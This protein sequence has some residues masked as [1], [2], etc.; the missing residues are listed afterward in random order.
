MTSSDILEN[1]KRN[2]KYR[3]MT[4]EQEMILRYFEKSEDIDDFKTSTEIMSELNMMSLGF[5]FKSPERIGKALSFA[6][7]T[8]IKHSKRQVYGYIIKKKQSDI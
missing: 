3:E 4:L 5:N 2:E 8:K 1:E 6:K 7:Y